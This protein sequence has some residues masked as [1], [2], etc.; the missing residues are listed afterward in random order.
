MASNGKVLVVD[1]DAVV[2]KEM[3][4]TLQEFGYEVVEGKD[5]RE[6]LTLVRDAQP[7]LMVMD[8]EMP[9]MGGREVC[10]IIKG[11]KGFGFMPI[12]LVTARD[13]IQTKVEGLELGAD[14][15]LIKPINGVE[16]AARAK[17]MM[18]MKALQDDV[19]AANLKLR[20][21]NER[22]Q[23][24]SMTDPLMGIYNRLFFQKRMIYEYQRAERYRTPLSL[25]MLDLDHFKSVNDTHG[26]PF[27]DYVLKKTGEIIT[28]S[29]RQVDIVARFGGEE[30]IVACPETNVSNAKIV[31][32]RI[33]AKMDEAE[34][35]QG[36]VFHHVT[37]SIGVA[38]CP[39][40]R[41]KNMDDFIQKADEALY[42]AKQGGRNKVC[43]AFN[44]EPE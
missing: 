16:L 27:G 32:E 13:D 10:R 26:H 6:A 39:D 22:L 20:D 31:G 14:D 37:V 38:V 3:A 5:G 35:K 11:T 18:R 28:A 1:D 24:L 42:A 19:V 25:L 36:E 34:F 7:D 17:S 4:K 44:E 21:A 9:G 43:F 40:D 2:R 30:L 23:D 41:I 29:V 33:R 8:V 12:I 15:Y